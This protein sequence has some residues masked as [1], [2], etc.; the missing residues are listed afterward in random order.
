MNLLKLY[1]RYRP[2]GLEI[3]SVSLDDNKQ[4]WLTAIGQDGSD[5]KNVSDLK[6]PSAIATEYL[7]TTI[8]RTFILDEENRIVAKNLRGKELEK[9]IVEMLKKKKE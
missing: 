3:I 2:R 1:K 4:A 6:Q 5:W 7:V 9:F 8:P